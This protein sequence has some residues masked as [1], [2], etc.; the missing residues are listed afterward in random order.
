ML[1]IG[2]LSGLER[3]EGMVPVIQTVQQHQ[4]PHSGLGSVL[5]RLPTNIQAVASSNHQWTEPYSTAN[6][7]LS[8]AYFVTMQSRLFVLV[9]IRHCDVHT[10]KR[11]ERLH[12]YALQLGW[13]ISTPIDERF[14]PS[15][16][17][18][19]VKLELVFWRTIVFACCISE[20]IIDDPTIYCLLYVSSSFWIWVFLNHTALVNYKL[21]I[22]D[23]II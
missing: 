15:L 22:I 20:I 5:P 6:L 1:F 8:K 11:I 17:L 4:R 7:T 9:L 21:F 23:L 16:V 3:S 18:S 2:V 13:A 10:W 19:K 12:S 14:G